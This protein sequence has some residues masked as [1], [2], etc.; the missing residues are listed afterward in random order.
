M[1]KHFKLHLK[2]EQYLKLKDG[3]KQLIITIDAIAA[4]QNYKMLNSN[5]TELIETSLES[6]W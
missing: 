6:Y 4:V 1:G 3:I 2:L 5:R